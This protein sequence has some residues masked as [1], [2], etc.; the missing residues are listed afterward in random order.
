MAKK[1]NKNGLNHNKNRFNRLI[2]PF[3]CIVATAIFALLPIVFLSLTGGITFNIEYAYIFVFFVFICA[4]TVGFIAFYNL[5][6]KK[7]DSLDIIINATEKLLNGEY[8]I[9]LDELSGEYKKIGEV[10]TAV[11]HRLKQAEREKDDFINDFSH[12][13]KTPIVSIRGFAKL[14]AKGNL[15]DEEKK[16]YLSIIVSESDRLIDLTA[17]TLMLDRLGNNKF[18]IEKRKFNISEQIRKTILLLQT[19]WEKKNIEFS[20]DF[21]DYEIY[22]A[23]ELTSRLFLNV[24][25]NAI[26]FSHENGL[27]EIFVKNVDKHLTVTVKDYGIGMDQETKKRMF[28]KY[29]RGD[30]SRSTPGN[31]LGLATVKKISELLD[32]DLKV[33]SEQGKGTSFS[34][35]FKKI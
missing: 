10:L 21:D 5:K 13:L 30:K 1:P 9:N 6:V 14:I 31:G 2:A 35:I 24:I 3:L 29:F 12:E 16:E 15:S 33:L 8:E 27:I 22:T 34:I 20:A 26:K 25:Q 23:E 18:D 17:S 32:V 28:D 7:D 11:G 19:E 4:I